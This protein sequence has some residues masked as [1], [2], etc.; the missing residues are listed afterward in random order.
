[1]EVMATNRGGDGG[2]MLVLD[3]TD[4]PPVVFSVGRPGGTQLSSL[5]DPRN[6][7]EVTGAHDADGWKETMDKEMA[8]LNYHDIYKLVL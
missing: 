3:D 5:A 1:M 6:V 7:R 8:T 4:H 2:A